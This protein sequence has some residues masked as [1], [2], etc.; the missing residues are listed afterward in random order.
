MKKFFKILLIGIGLV[1]LLLIG[2]SIGTAI[3]YSGDSE[4][5]EIITGTWETTAYKTPIT[6]KIYKGSKTFN[7]YTYGYFEVDNN[8]DHFYHVRYKNKTLE[9]LEE[10]TDQFLIYTEDQV[11]EGEIYLPNENNKVLVSVQLEK[12]GD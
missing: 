9:F 2:I 12:V 11:L 5:T 8:Q 4:F 6:F 3:L 7:G 10:D 1:V